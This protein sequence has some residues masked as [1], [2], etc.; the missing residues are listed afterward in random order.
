MVGIRSGDMRQRVAPTNAASDGPAGGVL[1][2]FPYWLTVC[3]RLDGLYRTAQMALQA[4]RTAYAA[5]RSYSQAARTAYA[6]ARTAY[7]FA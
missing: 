1:T 4:A 5:F 2:G 7:A 3:G 6:F